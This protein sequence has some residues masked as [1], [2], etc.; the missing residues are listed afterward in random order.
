[1]KALAQKNR[2]AVLLFLLLGIHFSLLAQDTTHLVIGIVRNS[3]NYNPI[4][5]AVISNQ[6]LK[7]KVVADEDGR[8]VIPFRQGD[9]LKITAIGFDDGFYIVNDSSK[10][11]NDFP[12]QLKPRT[13]ELK[14]FTIAPYKTVLQFKHALVQLDLPEEKAFAEIQLPQIKR[15]IPDENDENQGSVSLGGPITALYNTF[16]HKGKMMKKYRKVLANDTN[17]KQVQNRYNR[18][19]IAKML[20]MI[21]NEELDIFIEFC[22][23]DFSFLLN[24]TDYEL[25]AELQKKYEIYKKLKQL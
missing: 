3:S 17:N 13:Y 8:Y 12:I 7:T 11:I 10:I 16:S 2:K 24:S 15:H 1:M 9:L 25:I 22:R 5:F 14:E 23:F 4:S 6:M 19:R 18:N 20:P 21:P